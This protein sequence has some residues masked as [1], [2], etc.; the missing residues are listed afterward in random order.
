MK[1]LL[2]GLYLMCRLNNKGQALVMFIIIIPIFILI[3]TLIFDVGTAINEKNSVSN[4]SY[5]VVDYGLDNINT[6]NETEL[7]NLII[8]NDD[9][10][11]YVSADINNNEIDVKISKKIKGVIGTMFGFDLVEVSSHYNGK[12]INGEKRIERK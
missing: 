9:D 12:I 2:K 10:L 4:I 7:I 11:S 3:F 8:C 1:Y 5:M 6:I